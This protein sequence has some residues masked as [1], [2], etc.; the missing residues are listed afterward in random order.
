[1]K[2]FCYGFIL[3]LTLFGAAQAQQVIP[4]GAWVLSAP[5]HP[6][7]GVIGVF[8]T[9]DACKQGWSKANDLAQSLY[10]KAAQ[11]ENNGYVDPYAAALAAP[12]GQ[13][14]AIL[15]GTKAKDDFLAQ[16]LENYTEIRDAVETA[17]CAQQ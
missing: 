12:P 13:K 14:D 4:K 3:S 15:A 8:Q 1:V 9:A 5:Q 17:T 11:A 7:L 6:E 2:G 10:N 16:N